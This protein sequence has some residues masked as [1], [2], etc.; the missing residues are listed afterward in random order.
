MEDQLYPMRDELLKTGRQKKEKASSSTSPREEHADPHAVSASGGAE[1]GSAGATQCLGFDT[2]DFETWES[3]TAVAKKEKKLKKRRER[4]EQGTNDDGVGGEAKGDTE[5]SQKVKEVSRNLRRLKDMQASGVPGLESSIKALASE[6][7]SLTL[8]EEATADE[9]VRD[10]LVEFYRKYNPSKVESVDQIL[11][12]GVSPTVLFQRLYKKYGLSPNGTPWTE[13]MAVRIT[14]CQQ[15]TFEEKGAGHH[16]SHWTYSIT[17]QT[18]IV[19]SQRQELSAS[20]RYSDF[21]WLR[22]VLSSLFR[23]RIIP[24]IPEK[25]IA[26]VLEKVKDRLADTPTDGKGKSFDPDDPVNIEPYFLTAERASKLSLFL[27]YLCSSDLCTSP[28]LHKFLSLPPPHLYVYKDQWSFQLS[29]GFDP[30]G[31]RTDFS[32]A[33]K[34]KVLQKKGGEENG[35]FDLADEKRFLLAVAKECDQYNT[36]FGKLHS[37]FQGFLQKGHAVRRGEYLQELKTGGG[38]DTPPLGENPLLEA[39]NVVSEEVQGVLNLF[40]PEQEKRAFD[41]ACG[42]D[43]YS[44][45]FGAIKAGPVSYLLGVVD[46][47]KVVHE[48]SQCIIVE[49]ID[50]F[51]EDWNVAQRKKR[52]FLRDLA[53]LF[54]SIADNADPINVKWKK[55]CKKAILAIP[56]VEPPHTE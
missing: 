29:K 31:K 14:S 22:G 10:R 46:K 49:D 53:L 25:S 54:G 32:T 11:Q 13:R 2:A 40:S 45:L 19:G 56:D 26:G 21:E 1:E 8:S 33:T 27:D 12:T 44:S 47:G 39:L 38:E 41:A 34:R 16:L 18:D 52:H 36:E 20:R 55:K 48:S 4:E 28:V 30:S 24:P 3:P 15:M 9:P 37:K 6:L 50:A 7:E 43:F 35:H 17:T 51:K 5:D 23:A 42:C